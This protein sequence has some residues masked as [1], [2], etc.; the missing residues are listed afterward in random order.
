MWR[1][2]RRSGGL[3]V[4]QYLTDV[5]TLIHIDEDRSQTAA[6]TVL[7]LRCG[8]RTSAGMAEE[9]AQ[10]RSSDHRRR[11]QGCRVFVADRHAVGAIPRSGYMGSPQQLA[12]WAHRSRA[13]LRRKGLHGAAAR[14]HEK[15][16]EDAEA[17]H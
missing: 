10:G 1:V 15:D 11:Y 12:A 5:P 14:L 17:G 7:S 4:L 8:A 2:F 13:F 16:P 9:P 6:S 3:S